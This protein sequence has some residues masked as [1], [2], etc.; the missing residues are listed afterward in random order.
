MCGCLSWPDDEGEEDLVQLED[1][2]SLGRLGNILVLV[3]VMAEVQLGVRAQ[4]CDHV[5]RGH[6]HQPIQLNIAQLVQLRLDGV[7]Q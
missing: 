3:W 7:K 1:F 5:G 4:V 2:H 6:H